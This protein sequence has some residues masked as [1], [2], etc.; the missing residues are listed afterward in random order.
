MAALDDVDCA[1]LALL[2]EQGD[3]SNA[4][5]ARTVGL[6]PAATLRRVRRLR[7]DGVIESVRLIVDA[8]AVGLAIDAF[9]LVTLAEHSA[10]ADAAFARALT[11]LPNVVRAD[12]VAGPDDALLHVVAADAAELHR[13]LLALKRAGAE[14]VRTMLRLQT[15]KPPSPLPLDGVR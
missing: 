1:L 13:I 11:D 6:S 10:R 4:E 9:V 5:L 12:S 7:E 8:G 15:L 14:R 3:R 2:Q